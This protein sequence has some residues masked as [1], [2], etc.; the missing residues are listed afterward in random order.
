MIKD[1]IVFSYQETIDIV[2]HFDASDDIEDHV[3]LEL[4]RTAI[5]NANDA[6]ASFNFQSGK[7]KNYN[8]GGGRIDTLTAIEYLIGDVDGDDLYQL[9]DTYILWS[10]VSGI[11]NNYTHHNGN[12]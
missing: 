3:Q 8:A 10:Y 6:I 12:S 5:T 4:D 11:L 9:N 7:H 2:C 1:I